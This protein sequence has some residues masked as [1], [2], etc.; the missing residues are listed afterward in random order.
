MDYNS[1]SL[2]IKKPFRTTK[3]NYSNRI[4]PW[5]LLFLKSFCLVYMNMCARFD[6]IPERISFKILRKQNITD[7]SGENSIPSTKFAGGYKDHFSMNN[8][9]KVKKLAR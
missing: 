1:I 9:D 4:G 8:G 3:G 6:E 7:G 5:P 2:Y